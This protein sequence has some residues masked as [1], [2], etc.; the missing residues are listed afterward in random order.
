L[1]A[2]V[3]IDTNIYISA[4]F[5]GGKPREV[6]DLGRDKKILIFASLDIKNEIAEKLKTKFK[7]DDEEVNRIL[8]DFSTFT[9]PVKVTKRVQAVPND[10][11]DDKFIECAIS[12][13]A[14]YIVSGDRHL[15]SLKEYVGIR[16]LK[17]SEF[18]SNLSIE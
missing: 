2:K 18:L 15:L 17:A 12:C 4:I 9:I 7:L 3:V 5:W 10:P 6:I 13:N 1:A 11:E 8:L 16:I 14:D